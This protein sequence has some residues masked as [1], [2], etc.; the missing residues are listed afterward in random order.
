MS[1]P[2]AEQGGAGTL[3]ERLRERI[4]RVG[5]ITFRD[6]MEAALYDPLAG[7]YARADLL[8]WGRAGDYRTAPERSPLFAATFA[9][10]FAGLHSELG[11]PAEWTIFEAGAGAGHFAHGVLLTLRRDYP[12]VFAAT[13]YVLDEL[14]ADARERT[15]ARLGDFAERVVFERLTSSAGRVGTGV[16]FSNE[17]LDAFPVHRVAVRGGRLL[18][19][20]VGLS[21]DEDSFVWTE[22]EPSTPRLAEYFVRCGVTLA[23]GQLAEVNLAAEEWL[24]AA[25]SVFERG[26]LVTVDYGAE[27][28]ELYNEPHRRQ[29]TLRAFHRHGFAPNPLARPG[30][31]DLTTTVD[32]TLLRRVGEELGLRVIS[33]GPLDDFLLRAGL[34]DR[35][36]RAA[37]EATDG[38]E[39]AALRAGARELILPGGMSGSF[40]VLVQRK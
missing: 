3:S 38:A 36:E 12:Q 34:L 21:D 39:A 32:W 25:A 10:Y 20:Y 35:L 9:G 14:S 13:R 5:A 15:R 16:V 7:Y 40:Q 18:E 33:F 22:R 2:D 31:Q 17:L 23:E 19:Q 24:K 4:R 11:S 27:A 29:G 37:T 30:G 8:R 6:W 28:G 26:Y 1:A